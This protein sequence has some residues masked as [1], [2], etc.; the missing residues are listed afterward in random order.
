MWLSV[1]CQHTCRG[2]RGKWTTGVIY[3]WTT[4]GYFS[5]IY[6]VCKQQ[7]MEHPESII[8]STK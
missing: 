3:K 1:L 6:T 7:A 5:P 8:K 2:K 4:S